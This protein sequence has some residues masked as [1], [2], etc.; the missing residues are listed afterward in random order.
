MVRK[1]YDL[2]INVSKIKLMII[3]HQSHDN[4]ILYINDQSIER[5]SKFKYLGSTLNNK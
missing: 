3:S 5:M 1:E 4:V 2:N